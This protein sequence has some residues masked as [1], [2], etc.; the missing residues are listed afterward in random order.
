MKLEAIETTNKWQ[1][2][3]QKGNDDKERERQLKNEIS[4]EK[5]TREKARCCGYQT[6]HVARCA[7]QMTSFALQQR[8]RVGTRNTERE[9]KKMLAYARDIF[10]FEHLTSKSKETSMRSEREI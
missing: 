1:R 7:L 8:N 4:V 9:A 2:E 6:K 5:R 3:F 10:A